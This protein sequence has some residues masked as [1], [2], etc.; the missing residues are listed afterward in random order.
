VSQLGTLGSLVVSLETNISQFLSDLGQ[1]R[2]ASLATGKAIEANLNAANDAVIGKLKALALTA[3]SI[4]TVVAVKNLA[5]DAIKATAAF[6]DMA[7]RTGIAVEQLS[8]MS[9]VAKVGGHSLG[10]V[11]LAAGRLVKGL[12][13]ADDETKGVGKALDALGINAR[14][15]AGNIRPMG[16]LLPEIAR[17]LNSYADSSNKTAVVQDLLGKSG[18]KVLPFLNDYA[19]LGNIAATVSAKNAAQAEQLEKAWRQM[20]LGSDAVVQQWVNALIPVAK[21]IVKVMNDSAN[22]ADGLRTTFSTMASDG[23]AVRWAE[24]IALAVAAVIDQFRVMKATLGAIGGSFAVVAADA[25]L[26]FQTA[27]YGQGTYQ[28]KRALEERNR[29]LADANKRYSDLQ[30][31]NLHATEDALKQEFEIRRQYAALADAFGTEGKKPTLNYQDSA[32]IRAAAA[33]LDKLQK[34][35]ESINQKDLGLEA[36]YSATVWFL[37][38]QFIKGRIKTLD[39]LRE[40]VIKLTAQQPAAK[41]AAEETN[42]VAEDAIKLDE[43]QRKANEART[44]AGRELTEGIEFE[45]KSMTMI[46][47]EREIAIALRNLESK[48]ITEGI[49]GYKEFATR[50]RAAVEAKEG[51]KDQI[52][53]W[54]SIESAAHTAWQNIG[55]GGETVFRQLGRTLK[56]A[57]LDLLYQLTVKA[58]IINIGAS[59]AG[60]MSPAAF[61]AQMGTSYLGGGGLIGAA[62]SYTGASTFYGALTGSQ[63]GPWLPGTAGY[64]GSLAASNLSSVGFGSTLA[65]GAIAGVLGGLAGY[66]ISNVLGSGDRGNQVGAISGASLAVIGTAIAGPIGGIVGAVLGGLIGHFTDPDGLAQRSGRFGAI[67]SNAQSDFS[68]S[69]NFGR[70]G[71]TDSHWFS[72]KDMGDAF[73]A[74]FALEAAI[75]NSVHSLATSDQRA[76]IAGRLAAPREFNFGIEHGDM[77]QGLGEA[78]KSRLSVVAGGLFPELEA[79]VNNFKGTLQELFQYTAA[80]IDFKSMLKDIGASGGVLQVATD[81]FEESQH[82]FATAMRQNEEG[83]RGVLDAFDGTSASAQR[84]TAATSQYYL[85]QI[86]LIA[87]IEEIRTGISEM[88]AATARNIQ[89]AGLDQQGKY[90]FFQ[91]EAQ[92]LFESLIASSDPEQIRRYAERINADINAAFGLLSPEDQASASGDFLERLRRLNDDV[93]SRL[94]DVETDLADRTHSLLDDVRQAMDAAAAAQ[95]AAAGAQQDASTVQL[96]AAQLQYDAASLP[97]RIEVTGNTAREVG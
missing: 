14:D 38:Q 82:K 58:W 39:E 60:G 87:Q 41:K 52:D 15:A 13:V 63:M 2:Q 5:E 26:I 21:D 3:V 96:T 46:N 64:Y 97:H 44:K 49:A 17:K 85:A 33:E 73:R 18:A 10:E 45:L 74:V 86:Q 69:S 70:F 62:A 50:I 72:D 54:K 8:S 92:Q 42:K 30:Y 83:M 24:S 75:E 68:A 32:S 1:A 94:H 57:V 35:L 22:A 81:L 67:A 59:M 56:S 23:S 9:Q 47:K 91:T 40:A 61:A 90:D 4:G 89:L 65:G 20:S 84:L 27:V 34:I 53:M 48:G 16:D 12:S 43:E 51:L 7:E 71:I 76:A 79:F 55:Q 25:N 19:E 93:D 88:F 80:L 37:N 6:D 78:I 95:Q 11:E 29:T 66:G 77:S 31:L 28:F 36:D